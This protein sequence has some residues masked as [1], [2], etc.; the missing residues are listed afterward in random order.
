MK[1]YIWINRNASIVEILQLKDQ[2]QM[3]DPQC[4]Y[5]ESLGSSTALYAYV[6]K[7]DRETLIK[8]PAVST[9]KPNCFS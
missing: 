9:I 8:H 3:I 1:Y 2:V 5:V 4:V 6:K 7:A